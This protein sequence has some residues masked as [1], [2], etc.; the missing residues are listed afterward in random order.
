MP[1][2]KQRA[3]TSMCKNA[4]ITTLPKFFW[5]FRA[6]TIQRFFLRD[7]LLEL[8]ML[9]HYFVTLLKVCEELEIIT[10]LIS[11]FTRRTFSRKNVLQN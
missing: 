1:C 9:Y 8:H 7:R 2:N 11:R 6:E 5:Q 4:I 3:I 10:Y